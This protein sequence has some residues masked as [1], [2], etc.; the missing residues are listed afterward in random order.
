MVARRKRWRALCVFADDS[1]K[2][3]NLEDKKNRNSFW[4]YK[5]VC[6]KEN[7]KTR[8]YQ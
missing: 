3:E 5:T 2:E 4:V 8:F 6:M 7:K 1:I